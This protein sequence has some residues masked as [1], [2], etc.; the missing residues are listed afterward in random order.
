MFRDQGF[1]ILVVILSG[2]WYSWSNVQKDTVVEQ[3]KVTSMYTNLFL[4]IY[5]LSFINTLLNKEAINKKK[6]RLFH[7]TNGQNSNR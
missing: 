7:G 5:S 2:L 6:M 1:V 4:F 3:L